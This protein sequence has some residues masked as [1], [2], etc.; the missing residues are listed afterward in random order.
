MI[1]YK[2]LVLVAAGGAIG[3]VGR[4]LVSHATTAMIGHGFPLA[5]IIVNVSGSFAMGI[6]IEVGALKFNLSPEWRALLAVG[7]LGAFTTFST[8]S[9]D[10]VTLL[11]RGRH[12]AAL[13]YVTISVTAS[14]AA[15][16]AGL[17]LARRLY[18]H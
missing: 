4:Y 13:A 16:I 1:S 11:E 7:M 3:A 10:A 5:T 9:L 8:F 15:L 6:L 12:I 14:I 2:M 18:G 17:T